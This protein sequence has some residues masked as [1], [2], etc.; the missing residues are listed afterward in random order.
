MNSRCL[1]FNSLPESVIRHRA[2]DSDHY[3][4]LQNLW[5]VRLRGP[6]AADGITGPARYEVNVQM[7][8]RLCCGLTV[9]L[10]DDEPF[11]SHR[12]SNGVS[13]SD[14]YLGNVL[15]R[16]SVKGPNIPSSGTSRLCHPE[17]TDSA[18][19]CRKDEV[20][21]AAGDAAG[22]VLE[23]GVGGGEPFVA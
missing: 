12:S 6:D 22:V 4:V 3:L 14:G 21:H 18:V 13:Q 15:R 7:F 17:G 11:R 8:Y 19:S 23:V 16:F 2:P 5:V 20:P 10:D 9:G 1:S